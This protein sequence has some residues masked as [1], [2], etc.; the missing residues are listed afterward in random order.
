MDPLISTVHVNQPLTNLSQG[1]FQDANSFVARQVF[2]VIPVAQMSNIFYEMD[3]SEISRDDLK[4][5]LPSTES[6]G[7]GMTF[8]QNTFSCRNYSNHIDIDRDVRANS[9]SVLELDRA[10]METISQRA[11][12]R[13]ERIFAANFLTGTPWGSYTGTPSIK[14]DQD[15]A[16][17]VTNIKTQKRNIRTRTGREPNVLV[18][19]RDVCDTIVE[20]ADVLDR[21][22]YSQT[23]GKPALVTM[24]NLK[25]LFEVPNIYVLNGTYNTA[26]R[27]QTA[28]YSMIGSGTAMLAYVAPN[29]GIMTAS[30]GYTFAWT[31]AGRNSQGVRI[32]KIP[33]NLINSDRIEIDMAV[34]MRMVANELGYLWTACL[35]S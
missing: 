34:D 25:A 8:S 12:I 13:Q 35:T 15:T 7:N 30:V 5:R 17:I 2:P 16:I 1:Y 26:N 33:A 10:V 22:S 19:A 24:D 9:D 27:G 21:V 20:Q 4:E 3:F 18:L 23:N 28:S 6:E 14:W 29:P 31:G 11:L 32:K